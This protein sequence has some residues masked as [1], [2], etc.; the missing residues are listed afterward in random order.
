M[1]SSPAM[2]LRVE[3]ILENNF[4]NSSIHISVLGKSVTFVFLL[5]NQ[6]QYDVK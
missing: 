5:E 4:D 1:P 3:L 6:M 2:L